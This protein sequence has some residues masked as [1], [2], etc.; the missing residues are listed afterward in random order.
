MSVRYRAGKCQSHHAQ[1]AATEIRRQ[2]LIRV[3]PAAQVPAAVDDV[4]ATRLERLHHGHVVVRV[5]LEIGILDDQEVARREADA[6]ANRF[7]L[8][9]IDGHAV[10]PD[11]GDRRGNLDGSIARP[12]VDHDDLGREAERR[13]IDRADA[14]EQ[15]ADEPLFV[16]GG[17]D[18]RQRGTHEDADSRAARY[19][20]TACSSSGVLTPTA[21]ISSTEGNVTT[22]C[23]ALAHATN[24][25][26][27]RSP[28][29]VPSA[30]SRA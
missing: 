12:I 19:A 18:D 23:S 1:A 2:R 9:A 6:G 16:V 14:F 21:S 27:L 24:G 3:P 20:S 26:K 10:H 22:S 17:D 28:V 11:A 13:E 7:P 8:A 29:V 5:V 30:T 25:R 4:A 15:R